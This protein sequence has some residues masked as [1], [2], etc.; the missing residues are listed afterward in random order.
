MAKAS[1]SLL[2]S[3]MGSPVEI[4]RR[5][6]GRARR[7]GEHVLRRASAARRPLPDFVIVGAQKAGT[8][9]LHAY[10]AEHSLIFARHFW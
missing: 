5:Q 6:L 3:L 1:G 7:S 4:G 10:L 9:S 8:T 2:V